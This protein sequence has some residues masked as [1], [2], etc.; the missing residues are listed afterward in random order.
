MRRQAARLSA[1]LWRLGAFTVALI[2]ATSVG[3][4][5]L[6]SLLER[7]SA[8]YG[9]SDPPASILQRGH[10]MSLSS[11][12]GTLLRAYQSPD[13]FRIDIHYSTGTETR[14][15]NGPRSWQHDTPM[16]EAFRGALQLQAARLALPWNLLAARA[17]LRDLGEQKLADGNVLHFIE[18]PL[19]GNLRL[20]AEVH[21]DSGRVMR[22][23]GIMSAQGHGEMEFGTVYD[24]FQTADGR[25]YAA[26]E[27][28]FAMGRYIGR[29]LIESVEFDAP[30]DSKLFHPEVPGPL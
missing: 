24:D 7:I 15:L 3:A 29:S 10:T 19:G 22:S 27:L 13:Q 14:I 30:L 17:S 21:P 26:A 25:L 8:A 28:H 18:L 6:D 12:E 2:A 23:R 1:L 9:L 5:D 20:V 4:A 16:T 11:G